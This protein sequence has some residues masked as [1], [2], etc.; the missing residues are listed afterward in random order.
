[1]HPVK[2]C[3]A[4][5]ISVDS[6]S[7]PALSLLHVCSFYGAQADLSAYKTKI[8]IDLSAQAIVSI[9][10]AAVLWALCSLCERRCRNLNKRLQGSDFFQYH[11][12]LDTRAQNSNSCLFFI[13]YFF[14]KH[15]IVHEVHNPMSLLSCS[16]FILGGMEAAVSHYYVVH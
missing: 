2:S 15:M 14:L 6:Y 12:P 7:K 10:R 3:K 1:M 16:S 11:L 4:A 9:F 5:V 13:L 8:G